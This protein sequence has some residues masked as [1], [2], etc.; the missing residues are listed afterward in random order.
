MSSKHQIG[1]W[2][3]SALVIGNMVGSGIFLLPSTL[4]LYGGI[5]IIGWICASLGAILLALVFGKLAQLS[6]SSQGGPYAYTRNGL[7][8]FPAYLVAWGYWVS[9]W[10][11][12][13]AI[14][15]ALVGYLKVFFPVLGTN[16]V[17]AI[18]T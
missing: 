10:C 12:N 16:P 14:A 2:S 8:D 4:A 1:F 11:T 18:V 3:G 13:A 7:G 5:S 17:A 9:I 15:V 6:P